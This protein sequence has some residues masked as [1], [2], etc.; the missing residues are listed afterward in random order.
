MA[1]MDTDKT[2]GDNPPSLIQSALSGTRYVGAD[3]SIPDKLGFAGDFA[4]Q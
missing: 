1:T 4:Y 2:G 3:G